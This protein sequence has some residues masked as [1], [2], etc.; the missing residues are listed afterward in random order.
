MGLESEIAVGIISLEHLDGVSAGRPAPGAV[1]C[2]ALKDNLVGSAG[3]TNGGSDRI[4]CL[5]PHRRGLLMRLVHEAKPDER[6]VRVSLGDLGPKLGEPCIRNVDGARHPLGGCGI[7]L[8]VAS[9]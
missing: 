1:P 7:V 5:Y 4:G 9:V 2:R 8:I 3:R 6:I